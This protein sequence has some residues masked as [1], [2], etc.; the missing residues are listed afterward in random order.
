M[1]S[2]SLANFS[3]PFSF[4]LPSCYSRNLLSNGLLASS[5]KGR[6]QVR[7]F[8]FFSNGL[9]MQ[10]FFCPSERIA[11]QKFAVKSFVTLYKNSTDIQGHTDTLEPNAKGSSVIP[12]RIFKKLKE[13]VRFATTTTATVFGNVASEIA[14][15][16]GIVGSL[17]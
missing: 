9:G 4:A 14:G 8:F 2:A 6:T 11:D 1:P 10:V 16:Y 5:M 17:Q 12:K 7:V 15:R 3:F 13:G